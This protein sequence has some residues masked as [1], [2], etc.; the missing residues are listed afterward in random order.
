M[1]IPATF[2]NG[3]SPTTHAALATRAQTQF[4]LSDQEL[5]I[6]NFHKVIRDTVA[7]HQAEVGK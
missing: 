5:L 1:W 4:H 6:R 7:A 3:S 2:Q